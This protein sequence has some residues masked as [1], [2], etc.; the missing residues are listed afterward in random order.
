MTKRLLHVHIQ[1]NRE[2]EYD[3][4][5]QTV[6]TILSGYIYHKTNMRWVFLLILLLL[7]DLHLIFLPPRSMMG[8]TMALTCW[9]PSL[10]PLCWVWPSSAPPITCGWSSTAMP[11]PLE[12]ASNWCI[13]VSYYTGPK[14]CTHFCTLVIKK[15]YSHQIKCLSCKS[16]S[17]C[18]RVTGRKQQTEC[19]CFILINRVIADGFYI[20]NISCIMP[21]WPL[22]SHFMFFLLIVWV[23]HLWLSGTVFILFIRANISQTAT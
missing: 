3:Y 17:H 6:Q 9:E 18:R 21:H 11:R 20:I 19:N 4:L 14:P 7:Y 15:G 16:H 12:K 23:K 22:V 2:K 1:I 13:P 5:R 10:V 8:K